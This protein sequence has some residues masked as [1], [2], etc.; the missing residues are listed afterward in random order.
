MQ[1]FKMLIIKFRDYTKMA[2]SYGYLANLE[3]E[4]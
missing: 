1:S 4:K 3:N 2:N